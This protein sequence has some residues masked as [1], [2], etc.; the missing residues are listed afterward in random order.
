MK[1][2]NRKK[3]KGTVWNFEKGRQRAIAMAAFNAAKSR[4]AP[5]ITLPRVKFL[6]GN[7]E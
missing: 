7:V 6:E 2:P 3:P 4:P 5:P 1:K